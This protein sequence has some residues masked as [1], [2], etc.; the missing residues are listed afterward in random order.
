MLRNKNFAGDPGGGLR[1]YIY[2]TD[3]L[4]SFLKF[5]FGGVVPTSGRRLTWAIAL[6]PGVLIS[7]L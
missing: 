5:T 3:S 7:Y 1:Q 2:V 4:A 6:W